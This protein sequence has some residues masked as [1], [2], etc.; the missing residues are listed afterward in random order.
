MSDNIFETNRTDYLIRPRVSALLKEATRHPLTIVCAGAGYGKTCAVCEFTRKL[1][2]PVLWMSFSGN[3]NAGSRFWA[4]YIRYA[5]GWDKLFAERCGTL[6]FPDTEDKLNQFIALR[7]RHEPNRKYLFV[8]DDIHLI[9]NPAILLFWERVLHTSMKNTSIIFICRELFNINLT[10]LQVRSLAPTIDENDLN[11]TESELV[12]YLSQQGLLV[13]KQNLLDILADTNGWA[14]AVNLVARSLKRSPGYAGYAQAAM[15][16]NIFM[17]METEAFKTA[18]A[19]MQRFLVRLSLIDHLSADLISTLAGGDDALIAEFKRQTAYIRFDGIINAYLIHHLFLDF[20]CTKQSIL[21]KEE[22]ADTYKVAAN[23][24][25]KNGFEIDA[26]NY[27]EKTGDYAAIVSLLAALPV[28]MPVDVALCA[29]NIF[30]RAPSEAADDIYAFAVMHVR[31]IIRMG[32]WEESLALMRQYEE[33]FLRLPDDDVFRNRT[34]GLIYYSWGNV[35]ALMSTMDGCYDF[36]TFY[37]K[38]EACLTKAPIKPDQYAN[39]PIGMWASLVGTPHKD[40]LWEY[41]DIAGRSTRHIAHCWGTGTTGIDE[42]CEGELL[43]YQGNTKDA[44]PILIGLLQRAPED[45]SP[46]V[47]QKA[48]FYL[49]RMALL[50]G[51]SAE[52]EQVIGEMEAML[53]NESCVHRFLNHDA[54]RGWYFCTLRQ[55]GAVPAWLQERFAPYGHAYFIENM[56]NQ[57]KARYHY[58]TRNYPPLLA[59]ANK[60]GRRESVLYGK[61]EILVLEACARLQMKDKAAAVDALREAYAAAA[62][63]GIWTPFIELGKDMRT[64]AAAALRDS[65]CAIPSEWLETIKRKSA[66]FAKYQ[67]M[68]ISDYQKA[69]SDDHGIVLSIREREILTDLYYGLSRAEIA[70]KHDVSANTVNSAINNLFSKLGA[71]SVVDVVRIAVTAKLV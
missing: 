18:S 19:R 62:P 17:L 3:D 28:Q 60:V 64:L 52:A 32:R 4:K 39:M 33:R 24:C 61:V 67:S 15:R 35:R 54:A 43:F 71:S 63:N 10:D 53:E 9:Q 36:V 27:W 5:A 44:K 16:Q 30:E 20:L 13:S 40:A 2:V 23:W 7:K 59:Y 46:E 70:I 49:L 48:L 68:M 42:L 41:I 37:A 69:R 50:H 55:P 38:M 6:G 12:S 57:I 26:L 31:V 11:F 51:N 25:C 56:G 34:L 1:E 47:K 45:G 21:T 8:L 66:S 58:L 65:G 29:A 14:F 22:I